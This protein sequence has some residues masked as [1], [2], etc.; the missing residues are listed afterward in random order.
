[1][2][3]NFY[4]LKRGVIKENHIMLTTN[5]PIIGQ[6]EV[7]SDIEKFQLVDMILTQLDSPDSEV[8][9]WWAKEAKSRWKAYKEG[10]LKTVSYD[11]VMEK[12]RI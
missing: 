5:H 2:M 4:V 3:D 6:I 12:Y 10:K 11:E 8:D 1:V 9:R 7:M